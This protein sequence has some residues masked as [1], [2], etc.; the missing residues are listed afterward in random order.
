[1]TVKLR[2]KTTNSIHAPVTSSVFIAVVV[3]V[4][5]LVMHADSVNIR[6]DKCY[7]LKLE[8]RLFTLSEGLRGIRGRVEES[9]Y[10]QACD[11][12]NKL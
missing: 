4:V 7:R 8:Y 2:C 5:A 11:K 6:L 9:L 10:I 1:M 12:R 3:A